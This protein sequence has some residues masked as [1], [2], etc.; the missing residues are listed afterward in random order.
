MRKQREGNNE[1][2]CQGNEREDFYIL[3]V[4]SAKAKILKVKESK[5]N[6]NVVKK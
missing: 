1:G 2:V 4:C 3:N 5:A 6:L